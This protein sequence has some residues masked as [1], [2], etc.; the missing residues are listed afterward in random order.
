MNIRFRFVFQNTGRSAHSATRFPPCT[1]ITAMYLDAGNHTCSWHDIRKISNARVSYRSP[2]DLPSQSFL[3]SVGATY[4]HDSIPIVAL[5]FLW[6]VG[7][8]T[9][10][11]YRGAKRC[12]TRLSR[13]FLGFTHRLYLRQRS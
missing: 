10:F 13:T 9:E 5:T 3:F 8:I 4:L 7:R 6:G 12:Y 1:H 11:P 2:F